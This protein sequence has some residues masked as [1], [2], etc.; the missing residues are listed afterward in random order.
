MGANVARRQQLIKRGQGL[1]TSGLKEAELRFGVEY[2]LIMRGL[3]Q[4]VQVTG[5]YEL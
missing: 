3:P 5:N 2:T 1:E 4:R